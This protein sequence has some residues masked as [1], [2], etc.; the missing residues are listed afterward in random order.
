MFSPD[1]YGLLTNLNFRSLTIRVA[2]MAAVLA[3]A[4]PMAANA[5][6]I[7]QNAP[8]NNASMASFEQG[9]LAQSFKQSV[10]N[11]VG[12]GIFLD[13]GFGGSASTLTIELWN[14]LPNAGGAM[15]LATGSTAINGNNVWADVFWAQ[16]N[17]TAGQTYFLRFLETTGSYVISGDRNNGYAN[18]QLYANEGYGS[19]PAADYTFRTYESDRMA[20]VP[21]PAT[22][23]LM[24][25]GLAMIGGAGVIRRRRQA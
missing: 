12:A 9:D 21:E 2:R 11:I 5:Q 17:I 4:L 10:N 25:S 13:A 14:A 16:T 19:F 6:V 22:Y 24:V 23:A 7:N 1:V 8:T 18:G 3:L 20:V 15:M